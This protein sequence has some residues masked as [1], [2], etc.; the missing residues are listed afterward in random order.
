MGKDT[1]KINFDFPVFLRV[2]F[3][4]SDRR[5]DVFRNDSDISLLLCAFFIVL[6]CFSSISKAVFLLHQGWHMVFYFCPMPVFSFY[7]K[8]CHFSVYPAGYH[9]FHRISDR[10]FGWL[11]FFHLRLFIRKTKIFFC[12]FG[13][14]F[15]YGDSDYS[16]VAQSVYARSGR[17]PFYGTL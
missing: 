3:R 15:L 16:T 1:G 8:V 2:F 7:S 5:R 14:L 13:I 11:R 12:R 4:L 17:V 9:V 10:Y 6:F